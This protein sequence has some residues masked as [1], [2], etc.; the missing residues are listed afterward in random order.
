M[1]RPDISQQCKRPFLITHIISLIILYLIPIYFRSGG[2]FFYGYNIKKKD[3]VF[4]SLVV[5]IFAL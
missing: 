2:P 1:Y 4:L 5:I 3:V